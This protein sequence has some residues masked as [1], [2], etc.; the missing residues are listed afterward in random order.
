MLKLMQCR[1]TGT[2]EGEALSV[3]HPTATPQGVV[4]LGTAA[5]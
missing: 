4:R 3:G 2:Q 1:R 5:A